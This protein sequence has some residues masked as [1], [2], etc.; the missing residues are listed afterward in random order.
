MLPLID[1]DVSR[2]STEFA[3]STSFIH[4]MVSAGWLEQELTSVLKLVF[5]ERS[6]DGVGV[7]QTETPIYG[8]S[9]VPP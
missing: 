9:A 6:V 1:R 8:A 2:S 3:I 4:G 5:Q 7:R